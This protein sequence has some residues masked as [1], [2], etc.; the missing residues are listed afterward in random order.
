MESRPET[1][2]ANIRARWLDVVEEFGDLSD[3]YAS[4]AENVENHRKSSAPYYAW[5]ASVLRPLLGRRTLEL[6]AGPG[7]L[8][9]HLSGFELYVATE[10]WLPFYQDLEQ[11]SGARQD[12]RVLQMD[13]SE[14][15]A[16][17]DE[18]LACRLDSVFSTNMLEHIK[19]DI[20]A[21]TDM[22]SVVGPSGRVVNL[23][24]A[25]R[26]LYGE[27]DRSVG[28]FRRYER[29]EIIAKMQVAGLVVEKTFFFNQA[30]FFAWWLTN[31]VLRSKNTT[32]GQFKLFNTF[33]PCFR[34]MERIVPPVAGSC[35]IAVG[36]P[37]AQ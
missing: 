34:L 25:F 1:N 16:R 22:A 26:A 5:I 18:L 11:L 2:A 27:A 6:G 8:S 35:L 28:H 12:M 23:V 31:K 15:R 4:M 20:A 32:S 7:L 10:T 14:L 30:G 24:P 9:E 19:D 17:R 37:S 36:R 3:A 29:A 13:V 33:V 21:L